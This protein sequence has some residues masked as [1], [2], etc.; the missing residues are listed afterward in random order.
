MTASN[1]RP[2]VERW[3]IRRG[4]PHFI[5]GYS[6]R[7]DILTRVVP[8]LSIVFVAEVAVTFGDRFRG[9]VQALTFAGTLAILVGAVALVNRLRGRPLF[10]RPTTVGAPEVAVFLVAPS[11]AALAFGNDPI[12]DGV[13]VFVGNI[14]VLAAAYLTASYGLIPMVLWAFGQ[15]RHQIANIATLVVKTLPYLL[16]FSALILFTTEMWQVVDAMPGTYFGFVIGGM[17]GLGGLLVA[18]TTRTD[19]AELSRFASWDDVHSLCDDTPMAGFVPPA[20][21]PIPDPPALPTRARVNVALVMFVNQAI[22]IVLVG[23]S[24][25]AFY[26][27]FGLLCI[28]ESTLVSWIGD[29]ALVDGDRLATVN[30]VGHELLLTRQLLYMAGFVATFAGL[31]FAVQVASDANYRNE[32]SADMAQEVRQALAVRTAAAVGARIG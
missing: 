15:L 25:F 29:G 18:V 1:T 13:A 32:F 17:I 31:Q 24:V 28:R 19:M 20:T 12:T 7:E 21:P 4:I 14:V 5:D 30:F 8:L 22:Q 23:A 9:W 26:L 3:F 16:L 27:A 6:I 10:A 2:P 11:V